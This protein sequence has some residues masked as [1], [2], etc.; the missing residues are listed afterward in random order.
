MANDLQVCRI[1]GAGEQAVA[2]QRD[3]AQRDRQYLQAQRAVDFA[4]G[5]AAERQAEIEQRLSV[6]GRDR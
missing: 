4:K 2:A 1:L 3:L 5:N 6:A